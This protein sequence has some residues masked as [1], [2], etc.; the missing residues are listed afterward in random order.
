MAVVRERAQWEAFFARTGIEP[1]RIVYER[2]LEDQS[3]YV[4]RVASL[5]GIENPVVDQRRV[6]LVIQ[7]DAVSEEW[8]QRFRA[9]NGDP[10]V[11]DDLFANLPSIVRKVRSGLGL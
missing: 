7:R 8:K 11:P 4:D 2:F 1:L 6:D 3:S 9:E 5:V 10:S